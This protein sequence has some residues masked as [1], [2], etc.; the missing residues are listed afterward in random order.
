[1]KVTVFGANGQTG[2]QVVTRALAAGH[3]VTAF[4]RSADKAPKVLPSARDRYHVAVGDALDREAVA[5]A[6]ADA[7]AIVSA[8]GNNSLG[9]GTLLT[10]CM[11]NITAAAAARPDI[12][13]ISVS[14]VGTGE[15]VSQLRQ[16][17]KALVLT[18]LRNPI[19]DHEGAEAALAAAPNPTLT[20]RCVG[21]TNGEPKGA[22]T[23]SGTESIKG[24]RISRA[25]VADFIVT[26]LDLA[27]V[28]GAIPRAGSGRALAV[29]L[30]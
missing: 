28:P 16:P 19:R 7:D 20:V 27:D 18:T 6:I 24:S 10:D 4:V 22:L 17:F 5:A 29:S 12:P 13:I 2:S 11:S 8:I 25:D 1:M 14:T 23:A 3:D 26:H 30:W 15:S 21:L 9:A